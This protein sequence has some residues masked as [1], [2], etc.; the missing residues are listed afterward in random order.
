M[1]AALEAQCLACVRYRSGD[2]LGRALAAACLAP[3]FAAYS[4]ALLAY[5]TRCV[6][7]L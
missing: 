5:S 6:G 1:D 4:V 3:Y 7:R 2:A